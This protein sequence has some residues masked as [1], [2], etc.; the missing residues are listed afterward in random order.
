[1]APT[2]YVNETK[3]ESTITLHLSDRLEVSLPGNPTTGYE[4]MLRAVDNSILEP[5]AGPAYQAKEDPGLEYIPGAG[6]RYTLRLKAIDC[7]ESPV[8]LVYRRVFEPETVPPAD[9]FRIFV[10]VVP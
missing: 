2:L 9:E 6:G 8:H 3:A 1:M 4:W 7:G 5:R 10:R